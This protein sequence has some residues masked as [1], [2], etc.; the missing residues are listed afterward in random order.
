MH[1]TNYLSHDQVLTLTLYAA[2]NTGAKNTVFY[3]MTSSHIMSLELE[4]GYMMIE[5]VK[6]SLNCEM[7]YNVSLSN[8]H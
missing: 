5:V 7:N 2:D 6:S 3:S 1:G 8:K 4:R